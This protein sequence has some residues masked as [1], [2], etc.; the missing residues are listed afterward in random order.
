MFS[1]DENSY[2]VIERDKL[3]DFVYALLDN[4]P[5]I[6]RNARECQKWGITKCLE[7]DEESPITALMIF[8]GDCIVPVDF[9]SKDKLERSSLLLSDFIKLLENDSLLYLKDYHFLQVS[10]SINNHSR[11]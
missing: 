3:E 11:Q 9:M 7:K 1:R 10:C 8:L 2:A 4:E 6:L 5:A